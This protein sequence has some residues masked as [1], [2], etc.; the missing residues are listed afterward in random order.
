[1]TIANFRDVIGASKNNVGSVRGAIK[2]LWSN[3]RSCEEEKVSRFQLLVQQA[4]CWEG[5]IPPCRI[6]LINN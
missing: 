2:N 6:S 4:C 1:M 3:G 5:K